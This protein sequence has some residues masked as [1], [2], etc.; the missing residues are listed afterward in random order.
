MREVVFVVRLDKPLASMLSRLADE[1]ER[2]QAGYVRYLIREDAVRKFGSDALRPGQRSPAREEALA[3][4]PTPITP[5][6]MAEER[7]AEPR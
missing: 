5:A 4:D 6:R 7:H 2:S 1:S 3:A